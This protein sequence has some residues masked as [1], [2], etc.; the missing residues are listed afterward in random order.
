M[1]TSCIIL[2]YNDEKTTSFLIEEIKDYESLDSIVVV[3]NLSTDGS[4]EKLKRYRSEKIHVI[5]ADRNGGYGY[6]NNVGIR[7]AVAHLNADYIL[8]SNPDVH[9]S[10]STVL[11]MT[12]FL[13]ENKN[14]AIVAPRALTTKEVDQTL[15]AWKL[16]RKWDY[17][18]SASMVYLKYLSKKLYS[19][20]YFQNK[21]NVDVDVVPGSLLMV[22]AKYMTE[23]GMY[24]EDNFLYSEEEMLA[25]KFK[26][27][28]L[29][30]CLLLDYSYIHEHSISISK[31]FP[32]E[33][34]KKK[35]NLDSRI[36]VLENYYNTTK[37]EKNI[38]R[39]IS[40][41]ATLEN[42]MIFKIKSVLRN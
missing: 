11:K 33:V 41:M 6:G 34:K 10:E 4:F 31:S 1:T 21:K 16:Q 32:S 39:L 13:F 8:I 14:Y 26:D 30:T 7:Y 5:C 3:D 18:L 28:N 17:A 12:S 38:I 37:R 24:D 36:H 20:E 29:K 15:L 27:K 2:N 22:N 25:L 19:R 9:F 23:Y 42:K 40:K 35:M